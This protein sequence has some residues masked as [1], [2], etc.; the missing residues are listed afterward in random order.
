MPFEAER[1]PRRVSRSRSRSRSP[2]NGN[3]KRYDKPYGGNNRGRNTF[4]RLRD[5]DRPENPPSKVLGIFGLAPEVDESDLREIFD[6]YGIVKSVTVLKDRL[7]GNSRGFAFVDYET[8]EEASSAKSKT[9]DMNIK[10][11]NVRVDF[12]LTGKPHK[13]TPGEYRGKPKYSYFEG[14]NGGGRRRDDR[15]DDRYDRHDR[16]GRDDHRNDRGRDD[17]GY[18]DHRNDRGYDDRRDGRGGHDDRGTYES[19]RDDRGGRDERDAYDRGDVDGGRENR[20]GHYRG[21]D[22][23]VEAQ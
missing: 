10:G 13:S 4:N 17:R 3:G 7:T 11:R 2:Y 6:E 16:G 5:N 18:D 12:S 8:V 14:R 22:D 1:P 20:G 19:R 9:N 15:D 23:G 21:N